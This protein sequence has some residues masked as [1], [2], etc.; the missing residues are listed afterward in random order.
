MVDSWNALHMYNVLISNILIGSDVNPETKRNTVLI[1]Y[2]CVT[3]M[4]WPLC[5]ID[6]FNLG[7]F[8]LPN[9]VTH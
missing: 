8:F 9:Q 7:E 5:F 1:K 4:V 2:N 6:S 3:P